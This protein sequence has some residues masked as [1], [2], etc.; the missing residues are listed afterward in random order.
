MNIKPTHVVQD[1]VLILDPREWVESSITRGEDCDVVIK[2]G[3]VESI[4]LFEKVGEL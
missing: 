1:E 2:V 4:R 3:L